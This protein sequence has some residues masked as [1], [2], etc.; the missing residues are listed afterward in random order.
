MWKDEHNGPCSLLRIGQLKQIITSCSRGNNLGIVVWPIL[1][2]AHT[3][4]T[5][6]S[7][8]WMLCLS[9]LIVEKTLYS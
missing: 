3:E 6:K 2:K 8:P 1:K 9:A 7:V 5:L 4:K